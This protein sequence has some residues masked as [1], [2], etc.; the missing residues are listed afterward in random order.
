MKRWLKGLLAAGVVI[1]IVL[2]ARGKIDRT[3]L[4]DQEFYQEMTQ[5]LKSL[6]PTIHSFQ[7]TIRGL[8]KNFYNT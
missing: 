2:F 1:I 3:P 8:G 7:K 6:Q 4:P 5:L